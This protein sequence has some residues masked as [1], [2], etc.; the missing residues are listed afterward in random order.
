KVTTA[1]G[2]GTIWTVPSTLNWIEPEKPIVTGSAPRP[3]TLRTLL[4]QMKSPALI[5]V[6]LKFEVMEDPE[7]VCARA[8]LLTPAA[9]RSPSPAPIPDVVRNVLRVNDFMSWKISKV[10]AAS[11][12]VRLHGC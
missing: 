3:C 7:A 9:A 2:T 12:A 6:P 5:G 10:H 4:N 1:D 11:W 8:F